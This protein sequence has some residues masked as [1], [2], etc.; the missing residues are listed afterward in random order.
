M[1]LFTNIMKCCMTLDHYHLPFFSLLR[2]HSTPR[3]Q[4]DIDNWISVVVSYN[5]FFFALLNNVIQWF[6]RSFGEPLG[7]A[8]SLRNYCEIFPTF[9]YNIASLLSPKSSEILLINTHAPPKN[10][11]EM[12]VNYYHF[13]NRLI[14][15]PLIGLCRHKALL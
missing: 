8:I 6:N 14:H 1:D 4:F 7:S 11:N 15:A 12:I 5:G 10:A 9:V 3:S 13:S 2:H